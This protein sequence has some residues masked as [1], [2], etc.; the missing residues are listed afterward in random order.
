MPPH[1][2]DDIDLFGSDEDED[3]ER[4]KQEQP[5]AYAAKESKL[6]ALIAKAFVLLDVKPLDDEPI[7]PTATRTK[8][9]EGHVEE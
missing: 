1:D 2:D 5:A 3:A 6:L 4:V 9:F 8:T 7:E